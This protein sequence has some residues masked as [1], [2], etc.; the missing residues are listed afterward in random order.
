MVTILSARVQQFNLET[1]TNTADQFMNKRKK[2]GFYRL[3][4]D[5]NWHVVV[6]EAVLVSSTKSR[7]TARVNDQA[8]GRSGLDSLFN[9]ETSVN[10]ILAYFW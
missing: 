6:R 1:N 4:Y 8:C 3:P 2:E 10:N 7:T 5:K 9:S